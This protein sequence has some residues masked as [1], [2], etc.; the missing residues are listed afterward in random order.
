M[1][2]IIESLGESLPHSVGW[3]I[4]RILPGLYPLN[5]SSTLPPNL[6]VKK[7]Q[8]CLQMLPDTFWETRSPLSKM[9]SLILEWSL[10][11]VTSAWGR[12]RQDEGE[13]EVSL[14]FGVRPILKRKEVKTTGLVCQV[15]SRLQLR[16][17]CM[18]TLMAE[19]IQ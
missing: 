16:C 6:C 18:V 12:L 3:G 5:A 7:N 13:F 17:F 10:T 4:F 15:F 19:F 9:H 1:I 14:G 2:G 11:C 8:N